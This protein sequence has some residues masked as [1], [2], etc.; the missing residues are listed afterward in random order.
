MLKLNIEEK[1]DLNENDD[2]SSKAVREIT[3]KEVKDA[4]NNT[5]NKAPG[6]KVYSQHLKQ[7]TPK[8]ITLLTKIFNSSLK[9]GYFPDTWK[10]ATVTMIL[11]PEKDSNLT[12]SYRPISLLPILGKVME[13]IMILRITTLMIE[14][15]IL[16]KYQYGFQKGKSCIHQVLRLSEH[17]SKWL[18][19]KPKGRTISLFIDAEKAF[20]VAWH[21]GLRI[22]LKEE[23]F[24]ETLIRWISNW[25]ENRKCRVKINQCLSK[26][27]TLKAGLPQGSLLS[28]IFYIFLIRN[29]P[30]KATEDFISIFYADD[31][32]YASSDNPHGRRK[33][34]AG[35]SL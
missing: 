21:N 17:I 24:P 10:I 32:S 14:K 29:M 2:I 13:R 12:T 26:Q 22:M 25:L 11:K 33:K 35:Q 23:N 9:I 30:T 5:P 19:K 7:H 6:D 20:D 16:N 27:V 3:E 1:H 31:T 4:I 28:P 18:N 15:K 8:L 34:Y